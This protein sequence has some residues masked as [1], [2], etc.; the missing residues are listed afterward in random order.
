MPKK[1]DG[2][3][4]GETFLFPFSMATQLLADPLVHTR[5]TRKNRRN[6]FVVAGA[7]SFRDPFGA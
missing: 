4:Q 5:D 2:I 7:E 3:Y 1:S 6:D